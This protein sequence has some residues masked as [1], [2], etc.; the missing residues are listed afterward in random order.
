MRI[1]HRD[2]AH[3]ATTPLAL[4]R[5]GDGCISTLGSLA[6]T[7]TSVWVSKGATASLY[8]T[9]GCEGKH[10][11]LTTGTINDFSDPQ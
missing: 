3:R 7:L 10:W 4:A 6:N 11:D 8:P 2:G 1:A 9:P 5:Y